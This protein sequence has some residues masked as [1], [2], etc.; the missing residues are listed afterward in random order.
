MFSGEISVGLSDRFEF[1][2]LPPYAHIILSEPH[3]ER[4]IIFWKIKMLYKGVKAD[5]VGFIGQKEIQLEKKPN[6][7]GNLFTRL[8]G[9]N[10]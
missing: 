2:L 4:R 8:L 6:K 10:T 5:C 9:T 7:L 3:C 1:C